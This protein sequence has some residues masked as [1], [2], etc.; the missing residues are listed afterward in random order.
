MSKAQRRYIAV[1]LSRDG[2]P[3]GAK[4]LLPTGCS[5]ECAI[6]L[7]LAKFCTPQA[8]IVIGGLI[9]QDCDSAWRIEAIA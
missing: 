8:Q 6:K 2:R 4:I 9:I 7:M 5:L 1:G 3:S